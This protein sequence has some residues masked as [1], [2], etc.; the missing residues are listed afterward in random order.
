[1]ARRS[2]GGKYVSEGPE[3]P[4]SADAGSADAG[5][6]DAGSVDAG[7]A[8]AGS[9]DAGKVDRRAP[10]VIQG[11]RPRGSERQFSLIF[12]QFRGDFH[13]SSSLT[14]LALLESI[15]RLIF[16]IFR[17]FVA[18]WSRLAPKGPTLWIYRY[19]RCFVRVGLRALEPK[20]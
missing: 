7:S 12:G 3:R 15:F 8:D 2:A 6:A 4:G 13:S 5:S 20:I 14:A 11:D 10:K 1:M 19:G 17:G 16:M 9:A 18:R